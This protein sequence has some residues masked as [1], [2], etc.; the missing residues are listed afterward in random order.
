MGLI[1]DIPSCDD[2]LRRI[3]QEAT[4]QIKKTQSLFAGE[5]QTM[6][7]GDDA[8]MKNTPMKKTSAEPLEKKDGTVGKD[9]NNPGAELWGV[10]KSKL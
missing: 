5:A 1:H 2:L 9:V 6:S 8:P 4:E 7:N 10:G 3:E